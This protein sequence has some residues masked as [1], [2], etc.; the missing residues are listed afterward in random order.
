MSGRDKIIVVVATLVA[1]VVGLIIAPDLQEW[2]RS[3]W[4]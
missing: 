3:L 1:F 2:F 4:R